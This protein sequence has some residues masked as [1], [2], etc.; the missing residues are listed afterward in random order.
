MNPDIENTASDIKRLFYDYKR[1]QLG[2][3]YNPADR[4]RKHD[5]W[6]A[7]AE[8]CISLKASPDMFVRAAF[9]QNTV[10]GG[11]Y[12]T[13]LAGQAIVKWYSNFC[14][15][16]GAEGKAGNE[17][18]QSEIVLY[19]RHALRCAITQRRVTPHEYILN[20]IFIGPEVLPAYARVF[21]Y[22]TVQMLEKWGRSATE[23]LNSDPQLLEAAKALG[24][25][26]D[27]MSAYE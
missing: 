5:I 25:K 7:A 15:S 26:L 20:P 6:L 4:F 9:D 14:K 21:L 24:Y 23:E 19:V 11:P 18:A 12:P 13:S 16:I 22:P 8:K 3:P 2:K 27:F 1:Q 17:I 10:P